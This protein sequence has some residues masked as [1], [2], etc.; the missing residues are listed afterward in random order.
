MNKPYSGVPLQSMCFIA[1]MFVSSLVHELTHFI[2]EK[3]EVQPS[4]NHIRKGI[5]YL[6]IFGWRKGKEPQ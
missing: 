1:S 2:D 3:D 5:H 6:A 4:D